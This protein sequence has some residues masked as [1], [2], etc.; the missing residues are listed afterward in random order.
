MR[1]PVIK[2]WLRTWPGLLV[3]GCC[4]VWDLATTIAF[5]L[6]SFRR[7]KRSS[8]TEFE[9]LTAWLSVSTG[10]S[11]TF[12]AHGKMCQYFPSDF[13][14]Y[15]RETRGM[16]RNTKSIYEKKDFRFTVTHTKWLVP[17][18]AC[19]KP[20]QGHR[21]LVLRGTRRFSALY[22]E[23]GRESNT[24]KRD[25]REF[26]MTFDL[27]SRISTYAFCTTK[28]QFL[29]ETWISRWNQGFYSPLSNSFLWSS[30]LNAYKW[31]NQPSIP[32][33]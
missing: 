17:N 1:A 6:I 5:S 4:R 22:A 31:V 15:D 33:H 9:L 13:D 11:G 20:C 7:R 26:S 25:L 19:G 8:N 3:A 28:S 29:D 16:A 10:Q 27:T 14:A 21:Y 23:K 32:S 24:G 18:W 30:S 12:E 2:Q